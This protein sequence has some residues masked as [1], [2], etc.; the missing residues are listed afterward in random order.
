MN[1]KAKKFLKDLILTPSPSGSEQELQKVV[2]DYI[3][4]TATSVEVDSHGSLIATLAPDETCCQAIKSDPLPVIMLAGHC[5]Q[6]GL[7]VTYI[8]NDGYLYVEAVGG[9]D[10]QQ[11]IGQ[12]V[13]V[14]TKKGEVVGVISRKAS[15]L[16]KQN[17]RNTGVKI[18][19][20]WIDIGTLSKKET[21]KMVSIG[22]YITVKLQYTE[23]QNGMIAVPAL[24]DKAGVWICA[25][26]FRRIKR[27]KLN[28]IVC[29]VSTVQE[30]VG[31]R[32]AI[33]STYS[34]NPDYGI[35]VDVTHASDTP[36]VSAKEVGEVKLGGGPVLEKGPNITPSVVKCLKKV[37]KSKKIKTQMTASGRLTGTDARNIQISRAGVNTAVVS[38]PCRYLHSPV[39]IGNLKD[40]EKA[41]DLLAAFCESF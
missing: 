19:D 40:L 8:D 4:K 31:L 37:A 30:E 36:T 15:H 38:I 41:A 13:S 20:L 25:E 18:E 29:F 24:D 32:G 9:W 28:A 34:V 6:I 12:R 27:K 1:K 3:G 35:A 14:W 21:T 39:E 22:D 5:D 10:A 26:A 11:L 33:T 23:L 16:L 2:K 17:E 7:I